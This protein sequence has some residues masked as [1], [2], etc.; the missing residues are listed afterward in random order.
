MRPVGQP[1][2]SSSLEQMGAVMVV[3]LFVCGRWRPEGV[4]G[5]CGETL[6]CGQHLGS[7]VVAAASA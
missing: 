2:G 1:T 7:V 4:F 6:V 5:L 3:C